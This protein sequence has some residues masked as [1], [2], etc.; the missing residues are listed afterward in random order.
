MSNCIVLTANKS[1]IKYAE[2]VAWQL[3]QVIRETERI[4]IATV[5][6]SSEDLQH[7]VAE[8]MRIQVSD[9]LA[10]L[11]TNARLQNYAYWRIDAINELAQSFDKVLYLDCDLFV[12]GTCLEDIFKIDLHG[13]P[14]AAVRDVHQSI[15]PK[16]FAREFRTL[17]LNNA[18]YFNSGVLLIDSSAFREH[19][20][21]KHITEIANQ[22]PT[23]LSAHDQS[24]LNIACH[25]NWCELSPVW[26]WQYSRR[27][28]FITPHIDLELIHFAGPNK[29]WNDPQ[30]DLPQFARASFL[31]FAG[32]PDNSKFT[33]SSND[34]FDCALAFKNY[35]YKN[36]YKRWL[37][38]FP[39][40]LDGRLIAP[41]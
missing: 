3:R 18:P 33:H 36:A 31:R 38:Q 20:V 9:C 35:Y 6:G 8:I 25:Q 10:D 19:R 27:N 2:F 34:F 13:A 24:L 4:F 11:P 23:I 7:Q 16:R 29:P 22:T 5:D 14:I 26:N 17:N 1:Y 12:T 21:F 28:K 41:S 37:T 40:K 32:L 30:Y 39:N 15:R